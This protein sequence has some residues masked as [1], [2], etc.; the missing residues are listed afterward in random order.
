M[1]TIFDLLK[2]E[3][4]VNEIFHFSNKPKIKLDLSKIDNIQFEDVDYNDYPD[5]CDAF[6][7]SADMN[8]VE[9]TEEELEE[10]NENRGFVYEKLIDNLF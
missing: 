7:S 1:K 5:F 10:L 8:G 2:K 6:I 4:N 9:M 3:K